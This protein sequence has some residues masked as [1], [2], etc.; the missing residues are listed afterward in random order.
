M[1]KNFLIRTDRKTFLFSTSVRI[2]SVTNRLNSQVFSPYILPE[3]L[4]GVGE[5][6]LHVFG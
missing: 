5:K 2:V 6:M 1:W 3:L 4:Y